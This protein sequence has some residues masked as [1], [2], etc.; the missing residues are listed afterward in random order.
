MTYKDFSRNC[1]ACKRSLTGTPDA[2]DVVDPTVMTAWQKSLKVSVPGEKFM[3]TV[4][5]AFKIFT[6]I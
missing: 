6:E 1:G 3:A 2:G 4:A 5:R